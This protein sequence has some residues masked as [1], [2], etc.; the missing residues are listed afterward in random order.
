MTHYASVFISDVHLGTRGAQAD[1]LCA[2]FKQNTC[3]RL[4]LVGDIIDG[5]QLR[6]RWFFPQSHA[7]VIR[8]ILTAAKRGTEVT[9]ILGNHDEAFRRFV[10]FDIEIGNIRMLDRCDYTSITG[11]RLLVIHG[12]FFDSLMVDKRW[13]MHVGDAAYTFSIWANIHFNRVRRWLGLE[14]WSLSNWLKQSTKQ[15]V[16]YITH[17]EDHVSAYC[18]REGYDGIICGHIHVA[19][20]KDIDGVAYMNCGDWVE[21]ATALVEHADGRFELIAWSDNG[22]DTSI[23][24][25]AK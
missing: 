3:D 21:S 17:F 2:F 24:I 5:W 4:F 10:H 22:Q 19:C 12:D 7:N 9:Y 14:Y 13:L 1:A 11:K 25:P 16:A 18:K 15:A 20:T 23:L 6:R 8:R